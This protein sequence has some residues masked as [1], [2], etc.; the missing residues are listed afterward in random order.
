[1][2]VQSVS[3]QCSVNTCT[4]IVEYRL[5]STFSYCVLVPELHNIDGT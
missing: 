4:F 5:F 1:M 3:L 2:F